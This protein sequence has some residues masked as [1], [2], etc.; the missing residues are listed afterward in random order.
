MKSMREESYFT[1][2]N[3]KT[4]SYSPCWVSMAWQIPAAVI[5]IGKG[6]IGTGFYRIHFI[7]HYLF[8]KA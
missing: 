2:K 1:C 7:T 5:C 3:V 6:C 8:I 4:I